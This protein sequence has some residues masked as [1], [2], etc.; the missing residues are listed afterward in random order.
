MSVWEAKR[1]CPELILLPPNFERYRI[2]SKA[3]Y[4][5]INAH[6]KN[7]HNTIK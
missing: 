7:A 6:I 2:A 4:H 3:I 1:K 5:K